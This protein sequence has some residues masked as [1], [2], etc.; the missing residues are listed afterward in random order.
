MS[1]IERMI[2]SIEFLKNKNSHIDKNLRRCGMYYSF[3]LNINIV[4]TPAVDSIDSYG[5]P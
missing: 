3:F 5:D 2:S 4:S 1:E